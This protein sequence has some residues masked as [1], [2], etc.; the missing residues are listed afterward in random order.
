MKRHGLTIGDIAKIT[1]KSYPPIH[2]KISMKT[3]SRGKVALFDIVEAKQ[4]IDLLTK[5]EKES[6]ELKFGE[7]W[8]KEWNNRWGHIKDWYSYLFFDQ[9]VSNETS[10]SNF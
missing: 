10:V 4:I 6:L 3:T 7:N 5:K 8:T 9:V 1:G 2:K